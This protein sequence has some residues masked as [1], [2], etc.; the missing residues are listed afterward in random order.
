MTTHSQ[1]LAS[2][3]AAM[4][5]TLLAK[6]SV[7]DTLDTIVTMAVEMIDGCDYAG[8]TTARRGGRVDTAAATGELACRSDALQYELH[9]GPCHDAL[10]EHDTFAIDDMAAETRWPNYAPRAA[11]LGIGSVLAFQLFTE[12]DSLGALDL[13]A[14]RP[15]AFDEYACEVGLVFAAHAAV[16]FSWARTEVQLHEAIASRQVIGEAIGILMERRR[17]TSGQAFDV[18]ARASQEFN[19][20]LRQVAERVVETGEEP[21]RKSR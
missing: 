7:Q 13:Y 18:L 5:R 20:K 12:E 8:V 4:A 3:F 9:E 21:T 14:T 10:W 16:A 15:H 17:L 6:K 2:G 1:D 11:G 19:V